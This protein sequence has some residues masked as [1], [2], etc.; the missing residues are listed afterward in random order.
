MSFSPKTCTAILTL[1]SFAASALSVPQP[2]TPA[3][4]HHPVA[5]GTPRT[6]T[7][8][9]NGQ[10]SMPAQTP[11]SVS[12]P[13]PRPTG[14][15]RNINMAAHM[16]ASASRPQP[17]PTGPSGLASMAAEMPALRAGPLSTFASHSAQPQSVGHVP[18][19]SMPPHAQQHLLSS[20]API[21]GP[22]TMHRHAGGGTLSAIRPQ[23]W[24]GQ[25]TGR[26]Q[27]GPD[28][29]DQTAS[30]HGS[31]RPQQR[32]SMATAQQH[33]S[34][35]DRNGFP[36][37]SAAQNYRG[38]QAA[39]LA[40]YSDKAADYASPNQPA[41]HAAGKEETSQHTPIVHHVQQRQQNHHS[42]NVPIGTVHQHGPR[43][44]CH[45]Q[46]KQ[47]VHDSAPAG[48]LNDRQVPA[49]HS[50]AGSPDL[51]HSTGMPAHAAS[52]VPSVDHIAGNLNWIKLS[53][54]SGLGTHLAFKGKLT[55]STLQTWVKRDLDA[56]LAHLKLTRKVRPRAQICV[57]HLRPL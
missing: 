34:Q 47:E 6:W 39:G 7:S 1:C 16:P 48:Q 49:A 41:L 20:P 18:T 28:M 40:Q 13:Q 9:Q 46:P 53:S 42:K 30:R 31:V 56:A 11:P 33:Q 36:Q 52:D 21:H 29:P 50:A 17:R 45:K 51:Q 4:Q 24:P 5:A 25:P 14:P 23:R 19:H 35:R 54:V 32:S 15:N 55:L 22:G 12:G 10:P 26:M 2:T 43:T 37:A 38:Q 8:M 44:S 27:A 57:S 3:A